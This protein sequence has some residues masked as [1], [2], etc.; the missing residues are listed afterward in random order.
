MPAY[1][2]V[3]IDV[4]DA[5]GFERYRETVMPS[6]TA[7]GGRFV[8]RGGLIETLEGDWKPPRL[9]ILEFPDHARARAWWAS[10]EYAA[11][12]ALRL[13]TARSRMIL[14]DGV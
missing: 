6:I 9:A 10:P 13:A 3:E 2:L 5:G 1:I 8:V 12:K 4:H 14:V 7:Y 11:P